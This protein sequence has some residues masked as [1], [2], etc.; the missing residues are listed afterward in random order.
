MTIILS[1][2][3]DPLHP[4]HVEYFQV[5]RQCFSGSDHYWMCAVEP[6][7]QL[8]ARKGRPA[9]LGA[10]DR[11]AVVRGL[12]SGH[13]EVATLREV[14]QRRIDL[15]E[16]L[17]IVKGWDWTARFTEFLELVG[18]R[19][20]GVSIALL[21]LQRQASSTELLRDWHERAKAN[22]FIQ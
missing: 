7:T 2:S 22:A 11:A 8:E 10:K 19:A 17:L 15:R 9:F 4:G 5:A 1:G 18:S 12:F 20:P 6:D 3:F 13:V 16:D 21:N 14:I